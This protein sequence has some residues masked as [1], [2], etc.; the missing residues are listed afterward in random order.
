MNNSTAAYSTDV[1]CHA[2]ICH[3]DNT[4]DFDV[5]SFILGVACLL[6]LCWCSRTRIVAD[7]AFGEAM[8]IRTRTQQQQV[9]VQQQQQD[10]KKR[11]ARI[12]A[13][14]L[15]K[16]VL[17]RDEQGNLTVG[18]V[19]DCCEHST[20]CV[21]ITDASDDHDEENPVTDESSALASCCNDDDVDDDDLI[22][23]CPICLD[24]FA[25]N[26]VVAWSRD[27]SVCSHVFH[28]DCIQMWLVDPTHDSCPS[29]RTILLQPDESD[30]IEGGKKGVESETVSVLEPVPVPSSSSSSSNIFVI[31]HGLVSRITKVDTTDMLP[32]IDTRPTETLASDSDSSSSSQGDTEEESI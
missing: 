19:A 4:G 29:C 28:R 16:Q 23:A 26:D 25:V 27:A 12:E 9:Q 15:C 24:E 3:P 21:I 6:A 17:T 18:D 1:P 30:D 10:P 11:A 20:D 32:T 13:S 8:R 22:N 5:V 14:L 7:S 2:Y 31:I